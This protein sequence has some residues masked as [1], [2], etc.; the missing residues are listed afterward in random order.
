MAA[1]AP[2]ITSEL[3]AIRSG[4]ERGAAVLLPFY[5]ENKNFGWK[6]SSFYQVSAWV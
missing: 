1:A 5:Q 3:K 4:E 2:G 6:A